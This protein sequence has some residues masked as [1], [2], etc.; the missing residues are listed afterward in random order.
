MLSIRFICKVLLR[1]IEPTKKPPLRI[2]SDIATGNFDVL[3]ANIGILTASSFFLSFSHFS[4][5][6]IGLTASLCLG[7]AF[8]LNQV[9]ETFSNFSI[10]SP[11]EVASTMACL[12]AHLSHLVFCSIFFIALIISEGEIFS[13]DFFLF[14]CAY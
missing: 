4:N 10:S 12:Y 2:I 13:S 7:G 1:P 6:L 9:D 8:L 3:L 5:S 11:E 14:S